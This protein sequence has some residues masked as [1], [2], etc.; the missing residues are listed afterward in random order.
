MRYLEE[1]SFFGLDIL[2][3][4]IETLSEALRPLIVSNPA[5]GLHFS[6]AVVLNFI[7]SACRELAVSSWSKTQGVVLFAT[8]L[9]ALRILGLTTLLL[10]PEVTEPVVL[11]IP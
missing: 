4:S 2:K 9:C 7:R 11:P 8:M 5:T 1:L 6:K 10:R 3:E